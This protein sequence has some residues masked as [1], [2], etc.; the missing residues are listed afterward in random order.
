MEIGRIRNVAF[1][2]HGG[3][4]KT[5]LAEAILFNAGA[6]NRI[7]SVENGTS[8]MDFDPVEIKRKLSIHSKVSSIEWNKHLINIV[9]TPGY[10]N[11]LHETKA[12]VTAVGGAVVIASAITGVKA[13]TQ[14]VWQYADDND[15][16]KVVFVNKMDKDRADFFPCSGRYRKIFQCCSLPIFIPIG[17]END[18][19]GIIDLVKNESIHLSGGTHRTVQG[20][21][22]SRRVC[23][24]G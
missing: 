23:G 5:S 20:G 9:D 19:K 24:R 4:G 6:V 21:G 15:L 2:S 11:F 16:A 10:S 1:I 14:R 13:E 3:A 12:A 22:Y 18:F 17:K 7:G 8:F